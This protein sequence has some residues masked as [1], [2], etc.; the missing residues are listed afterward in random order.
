[1]DTGCNKSGAAAIAHGRVTATVLPVTAADLLVKRSTQAA[2]SADASGS[3]LDAGATSVQSCEMA[4]M[5]D[6][7]AFGRVMRALL[8]FTPL[9][10]CTA[11]GAPLLIAAESGE[12]GVAPFA[13]L[14]LAS[15]AA[16]CCS[17][18]LQMDHAAVL[19]RAVEAKV[20]SGVYTDMS[21]E[22]RV[23]VAVHLNA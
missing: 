3:V 11:A 23:R 15:Y 10:G 1:M 8:S 20:Y 18:V 12:L 19:L 5:A 4:K 7:Q 21:G 13:P 22:D 14:A 9:S 6:V 17:G 16:H 2:A